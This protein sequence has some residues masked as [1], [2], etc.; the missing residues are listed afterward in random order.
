MGLTGADQRWVREGKGLHTECPRLSAV[1]QWPHLPMRVPSSPPQ[2]RENRGSRVEASCHGDRLVCERNTG[3]RR[4]GQWASV[5]GKHGCPGKLS[6]KATRSP[7]RSAPPAW[8][9]SVICLA[10]IEISVHDTGVS[11]QAGATETQMGLSRQGSR[12]ADGETGSLGTV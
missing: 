12:A 1:S 9:T 8:P 2:F 3:W 10:V 4:C 11:K 7:T 5:L 6:S